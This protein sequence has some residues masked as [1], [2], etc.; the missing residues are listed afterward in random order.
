MERAL[1][2]DFRLETVRKELNPPKEDYKGQL[3]IATEE[4][5]GHDDSFPPKHERHIVFR[6]HC[7]RLADGS[8]GSSGKFDPKEMLIGNIQYRQLAFENPHCEICEDHGDMIPIE[9]RFFGSKYKPSST[10]AIAPE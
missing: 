10:A 1:A 7:Y 9:E 6:S 4:Q 8:I 5:F 2:G 3:R